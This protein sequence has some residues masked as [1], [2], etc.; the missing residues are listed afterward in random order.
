LPRKY[1]RCVTSI[2]SHRVTSVVRYLQAQ[3]KF[4]AQTCGL[5]ERRITWSRSP[6]PWS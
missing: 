1:R 4:V 3:S 2:R 5:Q 6:P